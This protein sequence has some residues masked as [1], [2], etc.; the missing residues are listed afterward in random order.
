MSGNKSRDISTD[1]ILPRVHSASPTT[2]WLEC[3]RSLFNVSCCPPFIGSSFYFC[4][5]LVTSVRTSWFSSNNS[6]V[7]RYPNLLS[8]KRGDA[9]SFRHSICPKCVRSPN[10]N[11]YSSFATLFRRTLESP[12][13]SR[14]LARMAAL[15]FWTTARSSAMV[16]EA[17]TFRMNCFTM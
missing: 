10:V 5:E 9:R 16:L 8:A 2:Y 4:N 7:P 15:S 11:R 13:S 17:R 12:L 3:L 6:M 14:K 1:A